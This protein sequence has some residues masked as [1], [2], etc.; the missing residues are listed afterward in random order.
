MPVVVSVILPTHNRTRC[1]PDAIASV[2]SQSF[3][4]LELIVVDD[5]STEDVAAVARGMQDGRVRYIRCERRAG[6]AAARNRGLAEAKG[7]LIAFQDS[8]DIWLPRKLAKQVALLSSMPDKVGAVAGAK[9]IYG[10]DSAFKYGSDKIAYA[11]PPEGRLRLD[12]NQV[13]HLLRENR[14]SLQNTLFRRECFPGDTWFDSCA[15]A[16]NDWEFAVRLVQH[17][18]VYEDAEPVVLGFISEDSISFDVRKKTIGMLRILKKNKTIFAA[19]KVQRSAI[20][21][22]ISRSLYHTG[23]R[24]RA[25]KFLSGA[26]RDH[27]LHIGFIGIALL[28]K[29]LLTVPQMKRIW[30]PAAAKRAMHPS[31]WRAAEAAGPRTRPMSDERGTGRPSSVAG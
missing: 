20:L 10:R 28:K 24:R 7:R 29:L 15:L 27:P 2:L 22:Q 23:K 16:N 4:D 26:L 11:P 3:R 9:I 25:M 13:D 18:T 5:G 30:S 19:R 8:D 21:I 31:D 1:L 14:I 6:A 12:E 17:T